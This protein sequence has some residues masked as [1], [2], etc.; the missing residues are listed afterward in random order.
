MYIVYGNL[1]CQ[2]ASRGGLSWWLL[3]S[4][5]ALCWGWYRLKITQLQ[6]ASL[7]LF[8]RTFSLMADA[9]KH[10][11]GTD[12]SGANWGVQGKAKQLPAKLMQAGRPQVQHHLTQWL[13]APTKYWAQEKAGEPSP[14]GGNIKI[15]L[16][17]SPLGHGILQFLMKFHQEAKPLTWKNSRKRTP[18][19]VWRG[20]A[21]TSFP[22]AVAHLEN[23]T[24]AN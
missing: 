14:C 11:S 19:S 12:R 24:V 16:M 23:L 17:G 9:S 20:A 2:G 22:L 10:W 13:R 4:R 3:T 18:D 5:K 15:K 7:L 21:S 6:S 1:S 8:I